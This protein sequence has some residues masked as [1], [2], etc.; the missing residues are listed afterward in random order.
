MLRE[1][2]PGLATM[3]RK[4]RA[5]VYKR[6]EKYISQGNAPLS[7][8]KENIGLLLTVAVFLSRAEYVYFLFDDQM[9]TLYRLEHFFEGNC[10]YTWCGNRYIR[11]I[12]TI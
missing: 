9:L 10:K 1:I 2:N 8:T 6:F 12:Q 5:P 4:D 3:K 7:I 11:G